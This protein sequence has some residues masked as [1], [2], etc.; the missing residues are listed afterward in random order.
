MRK[1]IITLCGLGLGVLSLTAQDRQDIVPPLAGWNYFG[2]DE[3]NGNAIDRTLWGL[4]GDKKKDYSNETYGNNIGQGMAQTY[5]DKMVTV[6]DGKASVLATREPIY[7]GL[8]YQKGV[9]TSPKMRAPL[10]PT[11]NF[12][13]NGWWSGFLSSRDADNGG[14]YYPLYSRIEIKAKIPFSIGTWMALWL[15]HRYGGAG[16]FEIDLEEFFVNDD[17]KDY[18][19]GWEKHTYHKKGKNFLHQSIHGLDYDQT[20]YDEKTKK[21]IPKTTSNHNPYADRVREIKFDPSKGFHVYGAQ[22]DPEPGDSSRNLAVTFL[23]DGR[24]RS[25]FLTSEYKPKNLNYSSRYNALLQN[26]YIKNNIDHIW[27]VA[28]TG[29]IGG[30]P[31]GKGGGVLY[32]ENDPQYGGDINRVPKNY[33]MDL[34]WLRVYKRTNKLL[35]IGSVPKGYDWQTTT[36]SINVPNAQLGNLQ[37]GDRLIMDI[38]TLSTSEHRKAG[39][40]SIDICDK[41]G[42]SILKQKP[43]IARNDAEVTFLIT[44][45]DMLQALKAGG[46]K[47]NGKNVRF[48]TL[49]SETKRSGLWSG[50]KQIGPDKVVLPALL[51]SN[52]SE[53]QQMEFT[54]RDVAG[55]GNIVLTPFGGNATNIQLTP[56]QDEKLYRITLDG[57]TVQRLRTNGL[58]I[59]GANY[60]LRGV[61]LTDKKGT[62]D[63]K[64][65]NINKEEDGAVY[66]IDGVKVREANDKSKLTPGI[67]ITNGKKFVVK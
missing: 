37:V 3:F 63:V 29:G 53:G 35:W 64:G 32:P 13:K 65:I 18:V 7:T 4:Y 55:G 14:T 15:R 61:R 54:V 33:V 11:H 45:N 66:T 39:P 62:T 6:Q 58:Q 52:V 50:F 1:I 36:V 27:D 56:S 5:R 23:L 19:A 47:I 17:Q 25:V 26:E 16:T 28:I 44:D 42:K 67:Y 60:Y 21:Y 2:G 24:V 41:T 9:D 22:I 48:F 43:E 20:E 30:K 38:D 51:F 59:S 40:V 8:R 31:D 10:A 12:T 49:M 34:D 57:Q 46:C